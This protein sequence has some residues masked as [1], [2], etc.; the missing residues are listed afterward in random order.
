M[1]SL[2][3]GGDVVVDDPGGGGHETC[4]LRGHCLAGSWRTRRKKRPESRKRGEQQQPR[5]IV[6]ADATESAASDTEG[7]W[8]NKVEHWPGSDSSGQRPARPSVAS[9]PWTG[10][11]CC[12]SPCSRLS[13]RFFLRVRRL[14]ARRC[15]FQPSVL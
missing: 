3:F 11:G 14:T 9:A 6:A 8:P 4:G 5:L 12:C 13:G 1:T 7:C 2:P 10:R 15:P